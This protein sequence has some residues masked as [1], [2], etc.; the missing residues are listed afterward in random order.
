MNPYASRSARTVAPTRR[1]ATLDSRP[2][3]DRWDR[4]RAFIELAPIAL[5]FE[6]MP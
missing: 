1:Q 2:V 6:E 4:V 3:A 5:E